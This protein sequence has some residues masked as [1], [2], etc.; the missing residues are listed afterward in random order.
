VA[1]SVCSLVSVVLI[2]IAIRRNT[3]VAP[4]WLR[5]PGEQ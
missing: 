4:S 3:I 2:V 1:L 5:K